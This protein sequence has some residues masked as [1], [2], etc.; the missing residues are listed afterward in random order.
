MAVE[1]P[2]VDFVSIDIVP[3]VAHTPRA[4]VIYEVYNFHD[5]IDEPDA[6]FD[7]VHARTTKMLVRENFIFFFLS[8]SF[9]TT[10]L[11]P[12]VSNIHFN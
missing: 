7:F 1:F 8:P 9:E 12:Q 6:S 5:G 11:S 10:C 3:M 4:N 2:H